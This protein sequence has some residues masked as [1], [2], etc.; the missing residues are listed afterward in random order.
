MKAK[1]ISE[2]VGNWTFIFTFACEWKTKE[3]K[4]KTQQNIKN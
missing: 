2:E 1:R 3:C 4:N